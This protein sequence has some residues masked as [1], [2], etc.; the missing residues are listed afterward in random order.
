MLFTKIV[1]L[2]A[3]ASAT[4]IPLGLEE[5]ADTQDVCRSG[6]YGQAVPILLQY[7]PA[8][9]FC[10]RTNPPQCTFASKKAKRQVNDSVRR[11]MTTSTVKAGVNSQASTTKISDNARESMLS[12]VVQQGRDILSTV[13]SCIQSHKV[14]KTSNIYQL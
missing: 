3:I 5:R 4:A 1:A 6:F 2:L 11:T 7:P 8:Q 14:S 13:C 10:A 12:S 9:I